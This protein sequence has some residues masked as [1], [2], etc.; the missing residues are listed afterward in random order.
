MS[1]LSDADFQFVARE[2]KM[3]SGMALSADKAHLL[4]MRLMPVA[5]REGFLSVQE[6]VTTAR[7]RQDDRLLWIITDTL[8]VNETSFFRD[9]TPFFALRD[10]MLPEL[11][12]ARGAG[13]RLRILCAGCS[14]GQEPYSLA[15]MLDEMRTRGRGVD[16]EIVA[17]DISPRALEKARAGLYSQFEVQRGLPIGMLVRH[18]EKS[19]EVWRISDRVRAAVKLQRANLI[20]DISSL[21]MF[22]VILCRNVLIYFDAE[23]RAG[24]IGRLADML[25]PDGYLILGSAETSISADALGPMARL[26]GAFRPAQVQERSAQADEQHR[27]RQPQRAANQTLAE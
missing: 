10:T 12:Q 20:D 23:T 9:R 14:T 16:C 6:L 19:S 11:A 3:R 24:A 22:D 25:A 5:R 1:A 4:E 13:A 2:A 18:F 7:A 21:G 8:A 15:M 27:E 26:P 17:I